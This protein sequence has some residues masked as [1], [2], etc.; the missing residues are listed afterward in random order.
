MGTSQRLNCSTSR[1]APSPSSAHWYPLM[2]HPLLPQPSIHPPASESGPGSGRNTNPT[3][4]AE[5]VSLTKGPALYLCQ[6]ANSNVKQT[7]ARQEG[8]D[9]RALFCQAS[10]GSWP[11]VALRW[12]LA[13]PQA[14]PL[15][16]DSGFPAAARGRRLRSVD[17]K[18]MRHLWGEAND[19]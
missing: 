7:R 18:G 16:F 14:G 2:L 1:V 15:M 12:N 19:R 5:V 11:R 8:K 6:R 10:L 4:A 13:N 17:G 3:V 9:K